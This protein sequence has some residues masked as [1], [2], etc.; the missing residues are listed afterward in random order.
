MPVGATSRREMSQDARDEARTHLATAWLVIAIL[1]LAGFVALTIALLNRV[2]FAFDTPLLAMFHAWD[3]T[4]LVWKVISETANIPLIVIGIGL[5][6]LFR[7]SSS[8]CS[9]R[10]GR[11]RSGGR[12]GAL[13]RMGRR[14][15][16]GVVYSYPS[17]RPEA[18]TILGFV[19]LR[20]WRHVRAL[21]IGSPTVAVMD[22]PVGIARMALNAHFRLMCSP[23]SWSD[24]RLGPPCGLTCPGAWADGV[25]TSNRR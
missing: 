19:A 7:S 1:S 23:V 21:A 12:V 13:G 15:I 22:N 11:Q 25:R 10:H 2:T 20:V 18:L 9:L 14:R 24:R 3:G 8:S 4:P 5:G 16:P 17:G 6:L